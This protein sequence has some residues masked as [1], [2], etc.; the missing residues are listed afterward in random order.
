MQGGF[1]VSTQRMGEII[2]KLQAV[3]RLEIKLKK[4]KQAHKVLSSITGPQVGTPQPHVPP[5]IV[6]TNN[7]NNNNS[8]TVLVRVIPYLIFTTR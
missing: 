2:Q 6:S 5:G 3:A 8:N 4:H 7:S 1:K